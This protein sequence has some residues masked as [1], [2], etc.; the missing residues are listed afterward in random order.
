MKWAET[1]GRRVVDK[2]RQHTDEGQFS[3]VFDDIARPEEPWRRA[4]HDLMHHIL[5]HAFR[6]R[7]RGEGGGSRRAGDRQRHAMHN[8]IVLVHEIQIPVEQEGGQVR[9]SEGGQMS[10]LKAGEGVDLE[11]LEVKAY[12]ALLPHR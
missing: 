12:R 5:D 7:E 8:G 9:P 4:T 3:R 2:P 1:L 11:I 10:V 6:L